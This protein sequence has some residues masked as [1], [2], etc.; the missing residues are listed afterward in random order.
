[1]GPREAS[2]P[3]G[4]VIVP[5]HGRRLTPHDA[6]ER[7]PRIDLALTASSQLS[8]IVHPS[9]AHGHRS[10]CPPLLRSAPDPACRLSP[11]T[12]RLRGLLHP[13]PGR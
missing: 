1:M 12:Y 3:T 7:H 8:S 4:P 6:G 11:M 10:G 2:R 5:E 13:P 9:P